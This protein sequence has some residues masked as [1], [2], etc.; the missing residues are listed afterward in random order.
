[1]ASQARFGRAAGSGLGPTIGLAKHGT[2]Q[3]GD[4][5]PKRGERVTGSRL[6]EDAFS[7]QIR[8]GEGRIRSFLKSE[9]ADVRKQWGKSPMPSYKDVFSAAELDDLVGYLAGL[10]GLR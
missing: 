3:P 10:R 1:M 5:Q 7:I 9:V 6:N 8:D 4:T 2:E